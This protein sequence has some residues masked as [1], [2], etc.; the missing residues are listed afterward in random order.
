MQA[1]QATLAL[2]P[3]AVGFLLG[4]FPQVGSVYGSFSRTPKSAW[5]LLRPRQRPLVQLLV[6]FWGFFWRYAQFVVACCAQKSVMKATQAT[7]ALVPPAAGFVW[8]LFPPAGAVY[9]SLLCPKT[10][11]WR[12]LRPQRRSSPR[13]LV[14]FWGFSRRQALSMVACCARKNRHGGCSG[15]VR[16]RLYRRWSFWE[17]YVCPPAGAHHGSL[18][19]QKSIGNILLRS[20]E[21]RDPGALA[22]P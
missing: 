18:H 10:S 9:G 4:V 7:A 20:T 15:N 16:D 14:L 13:P 12:L 21:R 8:G 19:I 6:L 11:A 2:G 17:V 5:R 3:T 1:A 22:V